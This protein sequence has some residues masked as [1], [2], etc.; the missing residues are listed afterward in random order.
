MK[1][2]ALYVFVLSL[3]LIFSGCT[4]SFS[5]SDKEAMRMVSE[6]YLFYD[7]GEDVDVS[8]VKRE[9]FNDGCKCYP[10][11][12]QVSGTRASNK[13]KTFYFFKESSN[14]Y[15][16]KKYAGAVKQ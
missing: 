1:Q 4:T 11:K 16:L 2:L 13:I 14:N 5:L 3:F 15:S 7:D 8:I 9:E 6:H 12:F 10:I